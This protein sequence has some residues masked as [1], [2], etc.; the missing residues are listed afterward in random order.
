MLVTYCKGDE[1]L[2]LWL[3]I[4]AYEFLLLAILL[5]FSFK[6]SRISAQ[7][8]MHIEEGQAGTRLVPLG[9]QKRVLSSQI[10]NTVI[11]SKQ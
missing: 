3:S 2:S 11:D 5:Y 7:L 10:L 1:D 6:N 4:G 9:S 8:R